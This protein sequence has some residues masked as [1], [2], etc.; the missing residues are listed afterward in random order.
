MFGTN[1]SAMVLKGK[2]AHDEKE[3]R[4]ANKFMQLWV[5]L[6]KAKLGNC[7]GLHVFL[8]NKVGKVKRVHT[9]SRRIRADNLQYQRLL[10]AQRSVSR[11][12]LLVWRK[13]ASRVDNLPYYFKALHTHA[14]KA[15]NQQTKLEDRQPNGPM[16][17][18]MW[19]DVT[20]R[21]KRV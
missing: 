9:L 16:H 18:R 20:I 6:I 1:L 4:A 12:I 21:V 14:H 17:T 19:H 13:A 8:S 11:S 15:S 5:S 10:R 3:N 2:E 7:I